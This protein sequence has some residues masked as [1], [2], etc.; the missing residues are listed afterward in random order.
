MPLSPA[1]TTSSEVPSAP[2]S[3]PGQTVMAVATAPAAAK[4]GDG[5]EAGTG[6]AG[7][8]RERDENLR[9]EHRGRDENGRRTRRG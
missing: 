1:P 4:R 3:R 7:A 8:R 2:S 9:E 6:S 5:I